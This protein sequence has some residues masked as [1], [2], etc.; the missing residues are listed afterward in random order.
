MHKLTVTI[1]AMGTL[2]LN[3]ISHAGLLDNVNVGDVVKGINANQPGIGAITGGSNRSSLS[4][5]EVGSGLKEALMVASRSAVGMASQQGGFLNNP[6]IKIPLPG[7]LKNA[8]GILRTVGMGQQVNE[9]ERSMNVAAERAAKEAFTVFSNAIQ[10]MTLEDAMGI[11]RGG[12]TAATAYFK[13]KTW[14]TLY[15]R[16]LPIVQKS[17]NEV[18]VTQQ[19]KTIVSNSAVQPFLQGSNFDLDHYVTEGALNGLFTLLGQQEAQI[20]QNPAARTTDLLKKVFG[21]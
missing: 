7:M 2:L 6:Q 4:E 5:P 8:A 20:R 17:V 14:N 21:N 10:E 16:F 11:L 3:S 1:L 12:D 19:Y 15:Q 9:F 18:G 13:R